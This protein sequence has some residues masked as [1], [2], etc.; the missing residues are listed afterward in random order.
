MIGSDRERKEN[1]NKEPIIW[2]LFPYIFT[3]IQKEV[4]M[5]MIDGWCI[6]RKGKKEKPSII[7]LY[8][9]ST[10]YYLRTQYYSHIHQ[11]SYL[12]YLWAPFKGKKTSMVPKQKKD[13]GT[14][15]YMIARF[16]IEITGGL[17][18]TS[19]GLLPPVSLLRGTFYNHMGAAIRLF[20]R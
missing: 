2:F 4:Q 8:I 17:L 15:V 7:H 5:V 9:L 12:Y 13:K 3:V 11:N 20:E 6:K 19:K 1:K 16:L 18:N 10:L 14:G